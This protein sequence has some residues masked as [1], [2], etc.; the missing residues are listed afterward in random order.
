MELDLVKCANEEGDVEGGNMNLRGGDERVEG[1]T[2]SKDP[3]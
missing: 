2:V 3:M 1:I